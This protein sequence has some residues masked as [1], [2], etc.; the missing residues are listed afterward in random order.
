[1]E[2]VKIV[3]LGM[4][5]VVLALFLKETKPE[6]SL[7]LSLAV[8]ICIFTFMAQ[9]LSYLLDSVLKIQEYVPVDTKYL[10]IL[11]KMIGA[12]YI[13]QFSASICKD[14]GYGAIGNQIEIFVK[15]YIMVMSMPVLLALMEAIYGFLV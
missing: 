10:T 5:G 2:V 3:M 6:Y 13:G 14:A 1:M 11:L 4:T 15:L 7:Y 12:A 8:G 9:K